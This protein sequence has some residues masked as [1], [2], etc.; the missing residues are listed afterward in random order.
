MQEIV[1]IILVI[2]GGTSQSS[3][4]MYIL[5][6]K[7]QMALLLVAISAPEAIIVTAAQHVASQTR[8]MAIWFSQIPIIPALVPIG[9]VFRLEI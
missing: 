9:G 4:Q 2:A 1:L 5:F 7:R 6:L 3:L 8:V